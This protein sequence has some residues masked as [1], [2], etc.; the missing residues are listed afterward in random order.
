MV[1]V[2]KSSSSV[3]RLD[4]LRTHLGNS[5][6][7]GLLEEVRTSEPQLVHYLA[8][9]LEYLVLLEARL[10]ELRTQTPDVL[11]LLVPDISVDYVHPDE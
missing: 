4:G 11:R 2:G 6:S 3:E 9:S 10:Q 5:V 1:K 8:A 7:D